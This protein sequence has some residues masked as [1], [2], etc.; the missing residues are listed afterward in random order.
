MID[1]IIEMIFKEARGRKN[2]D[3]D[4]ALMRVLFEVTDKVCNAIKTVKVEK[5][6]S[7]RLKF[8][9]KEG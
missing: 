9:R 6:K 8:R 3:L 4:L 5:I 7:T 1:D 2:Q